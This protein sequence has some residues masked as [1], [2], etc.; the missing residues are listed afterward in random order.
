[1]AKYFLILTEG[2]KTEPTILEEILTK[3]GFQV[4][5]KQQVQIDG[6]DLTWDFSATELTEG[7][8]N[9][10]IAQ[11]PRNRIRDFLLLVERKQAEVERYFSGLCQRF[12]G[13][14]LVYDVDHTLKEDLERMYKAYRDETTG[15]LILSSPCIEILSEPNRVE[16]IAVDHLETYKS[17]RKE[18]ANRTYGLSIEQYI[19]AHFEELVLY[20]LKKNCAESGSNNVMEHP[21]FVLEQIN[22]L[23]ERKFESNDCLPV[24]YRSFTTTLYVCL[25][26]I[27]GLTKEMENAQRV[28]EFFEGQRT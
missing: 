16:K 6:E 25:A 10:V 11:G 15:L 13:I 12:A 4:Q 9:V 26:Y 17:E 7:R 27:L 18:W 23:N 2:S 1:M 24:V 5:R 22:E 28:I 19:L 21:D 3:Y 14:F 8:G 20:Y